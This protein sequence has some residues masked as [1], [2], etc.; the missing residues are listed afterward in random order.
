MVNIHETSGITLRGSAIARTTLA[1]YTAGASSDCSDDGKK[2]QAA[3][4]AAVKARE[5][6]RE[7]GSGGGATEVVVELTRGNRAFG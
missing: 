1:E 4:T 5:A 3:A 7:A 2:G 6:E